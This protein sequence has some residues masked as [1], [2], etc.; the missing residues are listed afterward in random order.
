MHLKD[1][2]SKQCCLGTAGIL[3]A[4]TGLIF[5]TFWLDLFYYML[6]KEMTLKPN[7]RSYE[8]WKSPPLPLSIDIYLFNWTN[9]ENLRVLGEKPILVQLGPYRFREIKDK[10]DIAWYPKNGTVSFKTKSLYYF[11]AEGSKGSLDDVV[12]TLNI[13]ALSAAAK[14]KKWDFVKRKSV[15]IGLGLYS[16]EIHITKTARELLFEGYSDDMIDIAREMPIFGEDVEVPFDKFGW[17]YPRNGSADLMGHFN[18]FT[19]ENDIQ[20]IGKMHTWNYK[21]NSG[22][23]ES[24]CGMV[25]G[26]AGEFFPQNLKKDAP[27]SLWTPDM[28]RTLNFEYTETESVLGIEGYKYSG[29]AKSVDNGTLYP[30]NKCFC[31][32]ECV[33]SGVINISGCRFG[34]PVFMSYP[35]FFNADPF[36]RQQVLGL[37]P[38]KKRHEFYMILEPTTGIPLEVAARLQVNVLIEEFP[39]IT[40]YTKVPSIFFPVIWFEQKVSINE[41]LASDL[42]MLL[43][44]PTTGHI[45]SGVVFTIGLIMIF[46]FP[47][48]KLVRRRNSTLK[49]K[50]KQSTKDKEGGEKEEEASPFLARNGKLPNIT[51]IDVSKS[52]KGSPKKEKHSE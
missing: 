28:C 25:N 27:I 36:Y 30:E 51:F 50:K 32:D 6:G 26:S 37:M 20:N 34:T 11:D 13:I 47:V 5:A 52:E 8:A 14:S 7:S 3:L 49:S 41:E 42:K 40:L 21:T 22:A 46:W 10:V 39:S 17:F 48:D 35:H 12:T 16:Q 33:R 19:G 45:C 2:C 1:L 24:Y 23:F 31:G 15:S 29:T 4:A 9:P 18:M 43:S 44:I 38:S